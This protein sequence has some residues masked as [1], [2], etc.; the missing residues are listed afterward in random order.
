MMQGLLEGVVI[1]IGVAI[2]IALFVKFRKQPIAFDAVDPR[3]RT[4]FVVGGDATAV[5]NAVIDFAKSSRYRL[6]EVD[7]GKSRV[8]IEEPLSL[9]SFGT[10]FEVEVRPDGPARS[11]V[12]VATVGMLY[13]RFYAF[14]R[15]KQAFLDA[16]RAAA[17]VAA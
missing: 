8:V 14:N 3:N 2:A 1:G 4:S 9:F 16:L 7:Q 12:D 11:K 13:Q 10:L 15:S 17:S 6:R 5:L